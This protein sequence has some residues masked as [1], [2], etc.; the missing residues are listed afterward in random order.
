MHIP[1]LRSCLRPLRTVTLACAAMCAGPAAAQIE[2][3][4]AFCREGA[5]ADTCRAFLVA[6]GQAYAPLAGSR[7]TRQDHGGGATT[8]SLELTW[9]VAW[10]VGAM[11]NV[12]ANDAFGAA[13]L[14]GG[15]ANGSRLALKGR[16]RH[17]VD[18]AT[19]LDLGAG[20]LRAGRSVANQGQPG[21]HHVPATGFTGS[22]SLGLA[23]WASVGA[24]ADV[25][26]SS[27]HE[28]ATAYYLGTRLGTRPALAAT[29]APLLLAVA[30]FLVSRGGS[31]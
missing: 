14:A 17:W 19:A 27:G 18:A 23:K 21:N 6:E 16:Y 8:R 1:A 11:M 7:Y 20:V 15:D 10:E 2:Q 22:V 5:P 12:D 31:T 25:L 28:P 24:Q 30:I 4:R 13:V 26:F 9:Y 3:P 29:A